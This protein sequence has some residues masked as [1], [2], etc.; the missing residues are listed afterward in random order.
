MSMPAG[1]SGWVPSFVAPVQV[2]DS[3]SGTFFDTGTASQVGGS[4]FVSDTDSG[5]FTEGQ[6]VSTGTVNIADTDAGHFTETREVAG[7]VV[8]VSDSDHFTARPRSGLVGSTTPQGEYGAPTNR[9][10]SATT[11]D[12]FIG[13]GR[14]MAASGVQKIYYQQ[15]EFPTSYTSLYSGIVSSGCFIWLCYQPAIDGSDASAL[16]A[17]IAALKAATPGGRVKV[18][19][20]QEPQNFTSI[21]SAAPRAENFS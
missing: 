14:N 16:S 5:H 13:G 6:R 7:P 12:G 10:D 2:A 11:F 9:L 4:T 20:W 8:F 1:A 21:F 18:V 17:S 19:L 15:G 3:D